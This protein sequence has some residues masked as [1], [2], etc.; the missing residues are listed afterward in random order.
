MPLAAVA[1]QQFQRVGG[2]LDR[3]EGLVVDLLERPPPQRRQRLSWALVVALADRTTASTIRLASVRGS[4][5]WLFPRFPPARRSRAAALLTARRFAAIA[6]KEEN[7]FG[8]G[9]NCFAA[10]DAA[11]QS[12]CLR[13]GYAT[14]D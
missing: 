8:A 3:L 5:A 11:K 7:G 10:R 12:A 6:R 4:G 14:F 13:P 9:E 1:V 2:V